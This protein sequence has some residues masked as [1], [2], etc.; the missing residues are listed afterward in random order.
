[1]FPGL[2]MYKK[3][4][5]K[6]GCRTGHDKGIAGVQRHILSTGLAYTLWHK[7]CRAYLFCRFDSC[8]I[9]HI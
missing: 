5:L 6:D 7:V 1:M 9:H 4:A 2:F 3:T 8:P